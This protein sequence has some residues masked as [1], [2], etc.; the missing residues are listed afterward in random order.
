MKYLFL[1]S[2]IITQIFASFDSIT[3]FKANFIQSVTDEKNKV[4]TYSGHLLTSKPQNALWSYTEPVKKDIYVNSHQVTIVEPEIEQVIVRK[5][6]L[7][8]D[9][10]SMIKNAKH[11]DENTYEATYKETKFTI[12]TKENIIESINYVDE[13]D[14]KVKI[15]FSNQKQNEKIDLEEF[16]P[17]FPL[18][19]DVI[20][21]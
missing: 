10:F 21:D 18:D 13:F 11:I 1:I 4:L 16:R 9:F 20:R 7:S 6:E 5:I 3:S 15:L 2:L 19:F 14:N 17:K 12:N 8:L